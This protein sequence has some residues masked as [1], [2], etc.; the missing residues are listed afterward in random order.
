M[1]ASHDSG[2]APANH[3]RSTRSDR[4]YACQRGEVVGHA[5]SADHDES[6]PHLVHPLHEMH[7]TDDGFEPLVGQHLGHRQHVALGKSI[8]E[9]A[10]ESRVGGDRAQPRRREA[11]RHHLDAIEPL[12]DELGGVERRVGDRGDPS[13]VEEGQFV[14]APLQPGSELRLVLELK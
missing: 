5:V 14:P 7:R 3:M 8:P 4:P 1:V 10:G 9:V 13:I 12:V 2:T 11:G 6:E